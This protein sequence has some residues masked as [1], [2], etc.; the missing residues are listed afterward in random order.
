MG[1]EVLI[2]V[3]MEDALR[4]SQTGS[5]GDGCNSLNPCSNGRCSARFINQPNNNKTMSLNPCSNGRCSASEQYE[6][7]SI[8][9]DHVLILVLMEDALREVYS[10]SEAVIF[11][12]LNPCSNG[13]CSASRRTGEKEVRRPFCLNPCSNG[14]CSARIQL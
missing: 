7:A 12:S 13:R 4:E 10:A 8:H 9:V 14:R 11:R 1:T 6:D 2:L 5:F 3:L